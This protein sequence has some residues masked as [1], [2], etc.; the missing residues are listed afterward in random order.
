MLLC[1][2]VVIPAWQRTAAWRRLRDSPF[3]RRHVRLR[4]QE[5]GYIEGTQQSRPT[6]Y[7]TSAFD[8]SVFFLQT[9]AA[10]AKWPVSSAVCAELRE[11]FRSKHLDEVTA[12]KGGAGAGAKKR[13]QG[14]D[15]K[16]TGN[17]ANAAGSEAK[18]W[19]VWTP[20]VG[21]ST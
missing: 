2:V 8:T 3:L 18:N 5:H 17:G 1:F 11:A 10:A 20:G 13:K 21:L 16:A 15:A 6:R 9:R 19:C 14:D 4:A 12:R 7:K